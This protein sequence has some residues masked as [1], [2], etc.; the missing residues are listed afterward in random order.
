MEMAS[1]K[2]DLQDFATPQ[3]DYFRSQIRPHE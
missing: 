3:D 1:E 2:D